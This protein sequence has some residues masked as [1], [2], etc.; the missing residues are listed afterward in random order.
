L[1]KHPDLQHLV[2]LANEHQGLA[3]IILDIQDKLEF[4]QFKNLQQKTTLNRN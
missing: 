4:E 2:S 3:Q 1:Q